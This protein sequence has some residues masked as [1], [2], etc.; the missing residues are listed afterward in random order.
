MLSLVSS[1]APDRTRQ[2]LLRGRLTWVARARAEE[3]LARLDEAPAALTE[4]EA[5]ATAEP[6]EQR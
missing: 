1:A 2:L 6:F 5:L 3:L 4:M